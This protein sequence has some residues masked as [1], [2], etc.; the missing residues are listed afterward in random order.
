MIIAENVTKSLN[1]TP[2]LRGV[3]VTIPRGGL[4]AI[5]GPSGSGKTTFLSLL[6]GLDR[7]DGGS[8]VVDGIDL[9]AAS[10]AQLT[11]YRRER[12]GIVLQYF[13]LLPTLTA[14]ENVALA[15][16]AAPGAAPLEWLARVG[17]AE[18]GHKYPAQLS[19]GMQQRVAIARALARAP[20]ILFA[21]EPT[22]ALDR[23]SGASVFALLRELSASTTC[24]L[25]THDPALAAQADR[26]VTMA[27]GA[28]AAT[29]SPDSGR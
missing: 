5:V 14:L 17:L 25:V 10:E 9:R 26:I 27:D 13:H 16:P 3:T 2:V 24:V 22:G 8:L 21:D 19:G 6:A 7:A 15:S 12:V 28:T 18:A 1:G 29:A 20:A 4:T 11:A 23:E